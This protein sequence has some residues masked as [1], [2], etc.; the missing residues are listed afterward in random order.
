MVKGIL[1][2]SCNIQREFAGGTELL[3]ARGAACIFLTT[4][5]R[6]I[7]C[8]ELDDLLAAQGVVTWAYVTAFNNS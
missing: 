5:F 2:Q 1:S 6:A 4:S 3:V 7:R 8:V